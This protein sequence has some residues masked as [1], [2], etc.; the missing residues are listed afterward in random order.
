[1]TEQQQ[2]ED[3]PRVAA[4][5]AYLRTR[6]ELIDRAGAGSVTLVWHTGAPIAGEVTLK[7]DGWPAGERSGR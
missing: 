6:A 7:D 2:A 3:S 5:I 4:L 1:M